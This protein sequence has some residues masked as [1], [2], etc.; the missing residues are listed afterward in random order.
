VPS[1]DV[2]VSVA[3]KGRPARPRQV[4][5]AHE[6]HRREACTSCHLTPV[7]LAPADSIRTCAACHTDHHAAGRRCAGCHQPSDAAT[8][9]L[10]AAHR[11]PVDA[12]AGCD[13]CHAASTVAEL[14]PTRAFCLAC[15]PPGQDHYRERECSECHFQ[16]APAQLTAALRRAGEAP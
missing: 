4:S 10:Q 3:M 8:A 2:T 12:H 14:V 11:A 13:A 6:S 1:R 7:T 15:H 16:R 5:F 9:T